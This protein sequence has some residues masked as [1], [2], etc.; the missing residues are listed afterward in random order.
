MTATQSV[1]A[2]DATSIHS[3]L[4]LA[5]VRLEASDSPDLDAQ[6]L[7]AHVLNADRSFLFAHG[8]HVLDAAQQRAFHSMIERRAAGEPVAYIIGRC[9]FYDLDLIVTPAVL[10]PRPETELLL[11]EALRLTQSM[12]EATVADI[13]SGSGALAVTLSRHR[14][15]CS[16]YASDISADAL[17]I[18]RQNASSYAVD[19][20]FFR[21][22]LA[23]PLIE[24]RIK[25]DLLMANL[26]YIDSDELKSLPFSRWEPKQA[27][28][29]GADG[30]HFIRELLGQLPQVCA[31]GAQVLLEIGAD[32]GQAVSQLIH[33][34]LNAESTVLQDYAGLDRIVSFTLD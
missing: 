16:V 21:G 29:G 12:N 17:E 4:L 31:A 32:Q 9:G 3:A 10:I 22:N 11:E 6:A 2:A 30:L 27:L 15:L 14:P 13:G 33:D 1:L 20:T 28:D 8:D 18:A 34:R 26:P 5:R 25:V 23:Q 19:V 7:L 24:R